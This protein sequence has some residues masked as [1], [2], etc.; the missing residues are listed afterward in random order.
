M[1]FP[2]TTSPRFYLRSR[3]EQHVV[4]ATHCSWLLRQNGTKWCR[5]WWRKVKLTW[6]AL[7]FSWSDIFA[8][9]VLKLFAWNWR[10]RLSREGGSFSRLQVRQNLPMK[11]CKFVKLWRLICDEIKVLSKLSSKRKT[12]NRASDVEN[13][14]IC[15]S[16]WVENF[17][18]DQKQELKL[19][20]LIPKIKMTTFRFSGAQRFM[21]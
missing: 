4:L 9:N 19:T 13:A 21:I 6:T 2:T 3:K 18:L 12:A 5:M 15:F 17:G 7:S 8:W 1:L 20:M 10:R 16:S 14:K 11:K